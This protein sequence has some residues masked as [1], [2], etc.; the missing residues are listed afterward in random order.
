M[1]TTTVYDTLSMRPF[2][3][4]TRKVREAVQRNFAIGDGAFLQVSNSPIYKVVPGTE[5][6]TVPQ[7]NMPLAVLDGIDVVA[8]DTRMFERANGQVVKA[9][10]VTNMYAR[11]LCEAEWIRN[12]ESYE[13]IVANLA[14]TYA[15]WVVLGI[16]RSQKLDPA[17]EA[18]YHLAAMFYY[19]HRITVYGNDHVEPEDIPVWFEKFAT[20]KFTSI[21]PQMVQV[22]LS[23]VESDDTF[24]RSMSL[25][26]VMAYANHVA[27]NP[28]ITLDTAGLIDLLLMNSWMG[29]SD[30][31][32]VA[33]AVEHPPLLAYMVFNAGTQ[34]IYRR[35][36]VGQAIETLSRR[37]MRP[38]T[39]VRW[40][41]GAMDD[42]G[43]TTE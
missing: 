30:K 34:T 13:G 19:W 38:D 10:E 39:V 17:T 36:L 42:Y 11:A 20:R 21:T 6:E 32:I 35:T 24:T 41:K 9:Y 28:S 14:G 4:N 25:D 23:K 26:D 7:W 33:A 18:I 16:R 27:D 3:E 8:I 2:R 37:R 1:K 43:L 29:Q 22:F 5:T 31:E 40:M 12:K 15:E